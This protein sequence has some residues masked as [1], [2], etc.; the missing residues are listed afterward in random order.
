MKILLT[1]ANG[2]IGMRLLPVLLEAGHEVFC[3]VR[4]KHRFANDFVGAEHRDRFQLVEIDFLE[5]V[6]QAYP[7]DFDVAYYLIHS[8]SAAIGKFAHLE[9]RAA[10][11]FIEYVERSNRVQQIIYLSGIVNE[12]HL[13][14]HLASRLAVE[15]ILGSSRIPLTTLRA[16]III[17]SGSASFEIIRD[18]AEKL[19][20]MVAPKWVN[21]RCQPIA[22]RNV[23]E[24][25]C[26]VALC[27]DCY[28]RSYDIA[29]P[30][31]LTYREMLL[32]YAA[33][34]GL[35]RWIYTV[36][37]MTPRLSSYWLF[38]VTSTSYP[39]AVNLVDS[40]H[41]EVVANP[42]D[43]Y[44]RF[45]IERIPYR[46]AIRLAFQKI[47]QNL[48]VSSWRDA[49]VSSS[50]LSNFQRYIRVP[51]HGVF[52]DDR[53]RYFPAS[54]IDRVVDN[55]WSIGGARGWY[56]GNWMWKLRGWFDKLVGGIGL[57]RGRTHPHELH[58]GDAL[59]FWRVLAA[60]RNERRL[61][62]L[63]EMKLPGEA[64]LEFRIQDGP[65]GGY[66]LHQR[67]IFRPRGLFGRI[68]WFVVLPLHSFVFPGM[69]DGIVEFGK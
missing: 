17:G 24:L 63:A 10:N 45:Q 6:P 47:D 68:Y 5:P 2:Y 56:Y 4:D 29:G 48:V 15:H 50:R 59:D 31:I 27:T 65:E 54:E 11:H 55:L 69:L 36:P 35:H 62:L 3:C 16:G 8:L 33:V 23:I 52:T 51:K 40:M 43:L 57:R 7:L 18:L 41:V 14:P 1:G 38:L 42:C 21:T 26:R 37:V 34:R 61:L 9:S 28:N 53:K 20:I 32:E 58:P 25:L 30:D 60:D 64:W 67:A 49:L 13:S 12:E 66:Y 19:P 39:L 46:E 44:E 22:V